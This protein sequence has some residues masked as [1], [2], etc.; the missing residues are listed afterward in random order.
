[1]ASRKRKSSIAPLHWFHRL[2]QR[3]TGRAA[4]FVWG[5]L[6]G[7]AVLVQTLGPWDLLTRSP[8]SLLGERWRLVLGDARQ[9]LRDWGQGWT[10]EATRLV[11]QRVGEWANA[12]EP[13]LSLPAPA[14]ST[15]DDSTAFAACNEQFPQRRALQPASVDAL[16]SARA[17]CS[18]GF[19]VLYSGR[20]K[21]P[22][23]VVERLNRHRLQQAAGLARTDRFYADARVPGSQ[24]ADLSD[25][26]G[27]G[28]DR[29]HMAAAANQYTA[30]GMAQSFALTNM[31]PQ[32][33]TNNRKVWAKL[34]ADV[35]KY[36]QRAAGDVFVYTGPLYDIA[37]QRIGS[38]QVWVPKQL[39]KLVYDASSQRA[40]AY[41]LPNTAQAQIQRP[42]DYAEFVVQTHWHLLAGLPVR[43]GVQAGVH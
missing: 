10:D 22:L 21:T 34:E 29:G 37:P 42:M 30:S 36:A 28:Y 5:A 25:Y 9:Q 1:M 2:R 14:A 8:E 6:F 27:S 26:Q 23:V 41:V 39:F 20:T 11:K 24:R 32:D 43:A 35:R 3:L 16:W 7:N 33:P 19:A 15:A 31:V 13:S 12:P 17:L 40:W 18:D 38:N 4:C